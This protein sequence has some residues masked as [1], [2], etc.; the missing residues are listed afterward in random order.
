MTTRNERASVKVRRSIVMA[1]LVSPSEESRAFVRGYTAAAA[2][3]VAL[4][5][6]PTMAGALL[7]SAGIKQRHMWDAGRRGCIRS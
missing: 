3:L 6:Q 2:E 4:F 1:G 7:D 5:D